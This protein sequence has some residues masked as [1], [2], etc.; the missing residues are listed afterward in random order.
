[1]IIRAHPRTTW[2][3]SSG[4]ADFFIWIPRNP[5]K[6]PDSTKGIQGNA[7]YF[8]WIFLDFLGG[9]SRYSCIRR[10]VGPYFL[11]KGQVESASD[12]KASSPDMV[13]TSL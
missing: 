5:L 12:P 1:M 10:L 4:E 7:S 13:R 8:A 9:N 3:A 6:R 11:T 2:R